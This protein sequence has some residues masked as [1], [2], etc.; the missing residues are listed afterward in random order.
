MGDYLIMKRF[1]I[2]TIFII[3]IIL[4]SIWI[5]AIAKCEYLTY[6]YG[7]QFENAYVGH[8]MFETPDYHKILEYSETRAVVYYVS[9]FGC[10]NTVVFERQDAQ[11]S[12]EFVSWNTDW[13]SSGSA[14]GFV[15]P[16]IR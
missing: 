13:S 10:G 11:S 16:Y 5:F 1:F 9:W 3:V 7:A 14:D 6:R 2:I 12:W 4:L 8:T 15:W